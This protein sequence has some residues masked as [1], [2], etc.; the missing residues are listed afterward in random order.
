MGS[1]AV[2]EIRIPQAGSLL[3][4]DLILPAQAAGSPPLVLFI[5]GRGCGRHGIPD[6]GLARAVREHGVAT[7]LIDL[8]TPEEQQEKPH[9][10][11]HGVDLPLLTQRVLDVTGW[12]AQDP[13]LGAASLGL[14]GLCGGAAAA[15]IA[16]GRLGTGV[17]SLVCIGGRA[18]QAGPTA[19]AS[20]R[21]PTLLL[22]GSHDPEALAHND[23]A[24]QHMRC[25]RSV[26]VIPGAGP[27]L[28]D[29]GTLAHAAEMAAD[30]Y[31]AHFAA[32]A[33]AA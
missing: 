26:A 16:A 21:A 17:R 30:W 1:D 33:E 11:L 25:E 19:L 29:S 6:R 13:Q 14:C 15:L 7:L 22:A 4:G 3:L 5:N 12:M 8:L 20:V 28:D 23:A 2:R 9:P 27:S 31:D 32:M 24:Y 10:G 18:D